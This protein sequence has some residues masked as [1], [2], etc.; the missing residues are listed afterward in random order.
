MATDDPYALL[1]VAEDAEPETIR[2]AYRAL[3]FAC[4]PDLHPDDPE[5]AGRFVAVTEAFA[6]LAD[7]DRRAACDRLRRAAGQ[8]PGGFRPPD[9]VPA[10]ESPFFVVP[11]PPAYRPGDDLRWSLDLPPGLARQGGRIAFEGGPSVLCP[12]CG[13]AGRRLCPCWVCGGRGSIRQPWQGLVLSRTCP[14]CAGRGL[15]P[16]PCPACGGRSLVPGPRPA[17]VTVPPGTVTGDVLVA[18][19]AGGLGIGGAPD[20][21][22]YFVARVL[23]PDAPV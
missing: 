22:L 6:V 19:G 12:A 10:G 17:V 20:G 9:P 21:D 1:G 11:P 8:V 23:D 13:G 3:A 4:H 15:A 2:R 7:P 5:A 16:S 14:A 18:R